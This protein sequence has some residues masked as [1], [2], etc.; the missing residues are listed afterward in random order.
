[1]PVMEKPIG[2]G[3]K[4]KSIGFMEEREGGTT[5][6]KRIG[7]IACLQQIRDSGSVVTVY[8]HFNTCRKKR[9]K[10]SKV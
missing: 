8:K 1:M 5:C 9:R 2:D 3:P 4:N 6:S 7:A 10:N